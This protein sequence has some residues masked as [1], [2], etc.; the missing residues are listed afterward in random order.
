MLIRTSRAPVPS[1]ASPQQGSSNCYPLLGFIPL[2]RE[3]GVGGTFGPVYR[4]KHV[5]D[6]FS[7][8]MPH[9]QTSEL[10]NGL[11]RE[12]IKSAK[13]L[14]LRNKRQSHLTLQE[15]VRHLP[16]VLLVFRTQEADNFYGHCTK[17]SGTTQ[18]ERS[19][20]DFTG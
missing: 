16:S 17:R 6:P 14:K 12:Q 15:V 10:N 4:F 1:S 5:E 20:T 18:S 9:V 8:A 11:R 3:S 7:F 2:R 19:I 13:K